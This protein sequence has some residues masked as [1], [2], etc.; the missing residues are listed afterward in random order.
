MDKAKNFIHR[1]FVKHSG[2]YTYEKTKYI[3]RSA[4]VTIV[5]KKH[6]EFTQTAASHL[7][8]SGCPL[9]RASKGELV[10]SDI[11]GRAG[12][13]FQIEFRPPES[14][15]RHRYDF[16]LPS[17]RLLIEFH[18]IQHYK[19]IPFFGG[20]EALK[21]TKF[22]DVYKRSFAKSAGYRYVVFNYR[23]PKHM[24]GEDFERLVLRSINRDSRVL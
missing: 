17:H 16:Y 19:A 15:T 22:R 10:I 18:G 4:K 23:Q 7:A 1:S 8:G 12:V 11:L 13:D 5:C 21:E 3:S 6:G 24:T 14:L 9:C 20:E 2:K